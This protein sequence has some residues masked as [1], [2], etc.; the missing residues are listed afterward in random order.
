MKDSPESRFAAPIAFWAALVFACHPLQTQAVT[1]I[2]QRATCLAALFSLAT[3][4][5]YGK[6]RLSQEGAGRYYA[7]SLATAVLA[8]FSK[9]MAVILPF[10]VVLYE[11]F[12]FRQKRT[13][14]KRLAPFLALLFLIPA[15]MLASRSVN[16][17]ELRRVSEPAS[18]IAPVRYL[19][20]QFR[21]VPR[22]LGMALAPLN[23]N[24][25][26]DIPFAHSLAQ[27]QVFGGILLIAA[28]LAAA[29]AFRSRYRLLSFAVFWFFLALLPESS[30]LPVADAMFEH[31][32]YLPLAGYAVFLASVVYL[33]AGR[34]DRRMA[35]IILAGA[36]LLYGFSAYSRNFYWH[37]EISIWT[38]AI[39]K[40]PGKARVYNERGIA[41]IRAGE[42]DRALEDLNR[43]LSLDPGYYVA[44]YNRGNLRKLR[45]DNASA[46]ADFQQA[47]RL[48]PRY[49]D[50]FNNLG[51]TYAAQ[52]ETALAAECFT[53]AL[54]IDPSF[55]PAYHNR[56][57]A[58]A[59][60]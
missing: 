17:G 55:A 3:L 9:E 51:T 26:H 44:Y 37:N 12:F 27:P 28:I 40:S 23:Q 53:K 18:G 36:V 11:I 15:V 49:R 47:I 6:A 60:K 5:F 7:C 59:T 50:A 34:L 13:D 31:R 8:M 33:T 21:V 32:L 35:A 39:R 19:L 58:A 57:K 52:G 25:D 2:V 24:I 41:F 46:V 29:F 54:E 10:L 22:Y 48:H 30:L 56:A 20:T 45:G 16:V 43:A 14:W 42:Y 1:Y 4:Y 38:D